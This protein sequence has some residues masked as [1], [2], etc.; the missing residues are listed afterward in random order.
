MLHWCNILCLVCSVREPSPHK[1]LLM[2]DF[3]FSVVKKNNWAEVLHFLE[4]L[5]MGAN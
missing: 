4:L 3:Q 2:F 5:V 1:G